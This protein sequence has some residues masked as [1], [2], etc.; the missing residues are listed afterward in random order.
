MEEEALDDA[1]VSESQDSD[2]Q[3]QFC[4]TPEGGHRSGLSPR[5][6]IFSIH[7]D[8]DVAG[9]SPFWAPM[10]RRATRLEWETHIASFQ[11]KSGAGS[12]VGSDRTD[13]GRPLFA[14]IDVSTVERAEARATLGIHRA[15]DRSGSSESDTESKGGDGS[16][17]GFAADRYGGMTSTSFSHRKT[18]AASSC[19]GESEGS[20][21]KVKT[22][23]CIQGRPVR[24]RASRYVGCLG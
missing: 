23:W 13:N 15:G 6:P 24:F 20:V 4:G 2:K 5:R 17:E 11:A 3:R 10:G 9:A 16:F 7:K 1:H 8:E 22:S 21:D 18:L 12:P 19:S 14:G